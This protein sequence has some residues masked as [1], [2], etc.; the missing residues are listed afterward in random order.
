MSPHHKVDKIFQL[1]CTNSNIQ[2]RINGI[3]DEALLPW[4][5]EESRALSFFRLGIH[6]GN[7]VSLLFQTPGERPWMLTEDRCRY[8]LFTD[9][10]LQ[11]RQLFELDTEENISF[12][13]AA[14]TWGKG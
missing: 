8:K 7:D 14:S 3:P 6:H 9:E 5:L 11:K 2:R 10:L 12:S 13:V 4:G 1:F